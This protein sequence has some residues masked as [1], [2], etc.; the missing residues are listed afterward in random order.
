M[1]AHVTPAMAI[2]ETHIMKVLRLFFAR[3]RPA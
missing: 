1:S 3:T 2:A